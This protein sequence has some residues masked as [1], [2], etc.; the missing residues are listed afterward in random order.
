[1]IC[2][3]C[4]ALNALIDG[5]RRERDEARARLEETEHAMHM[6]IRAGYDACVADAWRA[7]VA[8][9]ERE[10][11]KMAKRLRETA[12]ILVNEFGTVGPSDAEEMA[13]HA[14]QEINRST[15]REHVLEIERDEARAEVERL[16]ELAMDGWRCR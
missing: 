3:K 16:R 6:R 14:V 5:Y 9:V 8:S 4:E 12:Q 2:E 13:K 7:K 15:E 10:R 1:M 11:D